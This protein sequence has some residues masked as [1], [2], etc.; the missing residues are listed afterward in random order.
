MDLS[1]INYTSSIWSNLKKETP[2]SRFANPD[3]ELTFPR[4]LEPDPAPED[5]NAAFC[6]NVISPLKKNIFSL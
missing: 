2:K 5:Q 3:P 4:S 6:K 1:A